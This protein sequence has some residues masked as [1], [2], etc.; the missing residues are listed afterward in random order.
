MALKVMSTTKKGAKGFQ[1]ER[2]V[3]NS[4]KRA[5]VKSEGICMNFATF[6]HGQTLNIIS[7]WADLDLFDFIR[8]HYHD[9]S[10]RAVQFTPYHLFEQTRCLANALHF[11]HDELDIEGPVSC[12]HLDL[13]LENILVEW[14]PVDKNKSTSKKSVEKPVG[15]WKIN[16]FGIS[17]LRDQDSH[18]R[19]TRA[20]KLAPGDVNEMY[21]ELSSVPSPRPAGAFLAPEKNVSKASDM[22]SLGCIVSMV[23]AFVLGGPEMAG[24]LQRLRK[25]GYIN[26]YFYYDE[27]PTVKPEVKEWFREQARS[28][29]YQ[30]L[31]SCISHCQSLVFDLLSV[32]KINRPIAQK[33]MDLLRDI[34]NES[35]EVPLPW[36]PK[37]GNPYRDLEEH[38]YPTSRISEDWG[39]RTPSPVRFSFNPGPVQ[40]PFNLGPVQI[41]FNPGPVQIPFNPG[42]A[43]IPPNPGP[44]QIPPNPGPVQIPF[45]PSPDFVEK[46]SPPIGDLMFWNL[47]PIDRKLSWTPSSALLR[48]E[49]PPAA[50]QACIASSGEKVGFVSKSVT[51]I[52]DLSRPGPLDEK[53]KLEAGR[54]ER[55][56]QKDV[57]SACRKLPSLPGREWTSAL[58]AG[59]FVALLSESTKSTSY[60]VSCYHSCRLNF[61]C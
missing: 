36:T 20:A 48:L 44:V 9:F 8:G 4:F 16:D 1:V 28:P 22:W 25:E 33:A 10:Q 2:Q 7:T 41:P 5:S 32:D 27:P 23:L 35:E 17:I 38:Q 21:R 49:T 50:F 60:D 12:A 14:Q 34:R 19:S 61:I 40:I 45:R 42:P 39:R 47:S 59:P 15:L 56:S 53:W 26:D 18:K 58:I 29:D 11:L 13:K 57:Y 52:Y 46:G 6:V 43:Q 55:I 3:L 54:V 31:K 51:Y 24:E 30:K 37:P